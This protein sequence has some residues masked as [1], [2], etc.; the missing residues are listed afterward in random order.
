MFNLHGA[1]YSMKKNRVE[2]KDELGYP[3]YIDIEAYYTVPEDDTDN[4]G[5]YAIVAETTTDMKGDDLMD[6][7]GAAVGSLVNDSVVGQLNE[8]L[9]SDDFAKMQVK[10]L[11]HELYTYF[12]NGWPKVLVNE[13]RVGIDGKDALI[14]KHVMVWVSLHWNEYVDEEDDGEKQDI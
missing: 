13:K 9:K 7:V 12:Y 4:E 3:A 10:G 11:N 14:D 8:S 5:D 6:I 1:A 2:T